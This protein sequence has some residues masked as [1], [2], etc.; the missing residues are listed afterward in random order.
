MPSGPNPVE[1]LASLAAHEDLRRL[2]GS[3]AADELLQAVQDLGQSPDLTEAAY[4]LVKQTITLA[5]GDAAV[6]RIDLPEIY[7]DLEYI[8]IQAAAAAI[9]CVADGIQRNPSEWH[10]ALEDL[11][12]R[13][14]LCAPHIFLRLCR[15]GQEDQLAGA[16]SRML[17]A[18]QALCSWIL[19]MLSRTVGQKQLENPS[20][21]SDWTGGDLLWALVLA[22]GILSIDDDGWSTDD[23]AL[24]QE[25][26]QL[27]RAILNAVL[28]LV[29]PSAAFWDEESD[30]AVPLEQRNAELVRHRDGL[31]EAAVACQIQP[32]LVRA[33]GRFMQEDPNLLLH[34]VTFLTCLHHP[35]PHLQV[36][37][38]EAYGLA[39]ADTSAS[40]TQS[41]QDFDLQLW[42]LL[43]NAPALLPVPLH[44]LRAAADL[45]FFSP[46]PRQVLS[47][48]ISTTLATVPPGH[49]RM[50]AALSV[51]AANA[52]VT[53]SET[54]LEAALANLEE[55]DR[56]AVA[57]HWHLWRGP[58]NCENHASPA[59][60]ALFGDE[61]TPVVRSKVQAEPRPQPAGL[62]DLIFHAP[63]QFRCALDGQLM[64]DPVR[65]PQGLVFERSRLVQLLAGAEGK[66]P[67]TGEDLRLDDCFRVPELRMQILRWVRSQPRQR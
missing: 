62:S 10:S 3:S 40:L 66:C 16:D 55:V 25:L 53:P 47:G 48:F 64:M 67:C 20:I 33:T 35:A 31:A 2:I 36:K 60:A 49:H 28:Q 13:L 7:W 26:P 32:T 65:T 52:Q 18:F 41:L 8:M 45:A 51:I 5:V 44:F 39:H 27:Q 4:S 37:H 56:E 23:V 9:A 6:C 54:P 15:V 57:R 50:L 11:S 43:A 1:Q 58:V 38:V 17:R 42:C 21:L 61:M 12:S 63:D 34:L 46:P 22:K 30:G 14:D 24:P 29:T 19:A 59:W